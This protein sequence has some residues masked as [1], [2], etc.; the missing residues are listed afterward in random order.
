[1]VT[2]VASQEKREAARVVRIL[3][4]GVGVGSRMVDD[5]LIELK[6]DGCE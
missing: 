2:I 1:M 3:N 5:Q 4:Q 6:H